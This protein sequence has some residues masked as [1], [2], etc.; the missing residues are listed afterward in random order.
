[1]NN[2]VCLIV[3][4][5]VFEYV[6][7]TYVLFIS[8]V[9][10]ML[11]GILRNCEIISEP[12]KNISR[13]IVFITTIINIIFFNYIKFGVI[14]L[15]EVLIPAVFILFITLVIS[16]IIRILTIPFRLC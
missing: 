12:I 9:V 16:L 13:N 8:G 10:D 14:I 6:S 4:S 1:M 5:E 15:V 3:C 7:L 11:L 2:S